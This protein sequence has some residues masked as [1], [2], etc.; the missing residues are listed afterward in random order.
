MAIC[1]WCDREMT[2]A[3]SCTVN[4]LYQGGVEV[5]V[6][7]FDSGRGQPRMERCGDCGDCGVSRRGYHHPGCDLQR[8]PVCRRQMISCDCRFDEDPP[9]MVDDFDEVH[10]APW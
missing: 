3:T 8:C 2:E 7:K 1:T 4:V 6:A 5:A 10:E 9:D